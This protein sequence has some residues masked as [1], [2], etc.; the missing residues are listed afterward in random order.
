MYAYFW[1]DSIIDG[2][3]ADSQNHLLYYTD[4]GRDLIGAVSLLTSSP[5]QTIVVSEGLQEP[6][7]IVLCPSDG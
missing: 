1:T 7:D 5:R 2:L 6:R 3:A 4:A